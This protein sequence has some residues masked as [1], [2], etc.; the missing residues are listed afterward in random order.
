MVSRES[1]D[2]VGLPSPRQR[3]ISCSAAPLTV[4]YAFMSKRSEKATV[5][6]ARAFAVPRRLAGRRIIEIATGKL[7]VSVPTGQP[8]HVRYLDTFDRR[9]HRAGFVLEHVTLPGEAV[10]RYREA[11]RSAAIVEAPGARLPAFAGDL[12]HARLRSLLSPLIDVRRL[13]VI[14]ES[15]GRL[16]VARGCD[17]EDKTVLVVECFAAPRGPARL[18]VRPLRG[19]ERFA[20]RAV[21]RL[22]KVQGVV[23][24]E[25]EPMLVA[26]PGPDATFG[27][28]AVPARIDLDPKERSDAACRRVLAGLDAVLE[29]NAPGVEADLDPEC[30][31]DFR[32]ATRKARSLLREMKGVFPRSVTRRLRAD[33]GWLGQRTGPVRDL[34]VHLLDLGSAAGNREEEPGSA[35]AAL[36]T[37]LEA[38]REREYRAL[39]RTLRSARYQ[40]VRAAFTQFVATEPPAQPRSENALVPI[41]ALSAT[42]ILKVYRRILAEGRAIGDDSPAES[43][44]DLRKTCKRLRYLLEFFRDLHPAK[45][46]ERTI[47]R[48]KR[49]QNN[50]G[51]YQDVQV[52]RAVLEEFRERARA[53]LDA[54]AVGV[55]DD[56]CATLA[57]RERKTRAEFAAR[58]ASYDTKRAHKAFAAAL[59]RKRR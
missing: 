4:D 12:A 1:P 42:C 51:T 55:I 33:L 2:D 50:L 28:V 34:D 32:V 37:D 44:H 17:R 3:R 41:G 22:R 46:V 35:P 54:V 6:E 7:T 36:R 19:Y 40:R 47:A 15:R 5:I 56:Q 58:F 48:L 26:D 39:G 10:L 29:M 11:G 59:G 57:E 43:L 18:T 21:R 8:A 53:S 9:L 14:G 38:L 52:Q 16:T 13:L 30:L 27:G 31:H 20:R 23:P 49:L 24:D 25:S 45:P